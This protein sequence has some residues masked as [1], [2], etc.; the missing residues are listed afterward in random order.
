MTRQSRKT[1]DKIEIVGPYNILQQYDQKGMTKEVL[2]STVSAVKGIAA[3]LR[4]GK[5][6]YWSEQYRK[7]VSAGGKNA[8]NQMGDLQ[9]QINNIGDIL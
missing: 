9:D 7:F 8:T 3:V 6:T 5:E 4:G 1:V 2:T